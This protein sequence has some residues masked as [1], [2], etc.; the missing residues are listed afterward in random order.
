[1][2]KIRFKKLLILT[3][4]LSFASFSLY[5]IQ[6]Y[7]LRQFFL[8]IHNESAS[9]LEFAKKVNTKIHLM[10]RTYRE[11]IAAKDEN[12]DYRYRFIHKILNGTGLC[13]HRSLLFISVMKEFSIPSR[14]LLIGISDNIVH[15]IIAEA[16]IDGRW[17]VFDPL[18]G[19]NYNETVHELKASN[20]T[21]LNIVNNTRNP[22]PRSYP[23]EEYHFNE[24][25]YFN[26]YKTK[27]TLKLK[28]MI[29][30][31]SEGFVPPYYFYRPFFIL[32]ALFLIISI[33]L[34]FIKTRS[35]DKL[36]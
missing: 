36:S 11:K 24:T 29:G 26:W 22:H 27:L 9:N 8:T 6:N 32:G 2:Y 7:E 30:V 14:K 5:F 19:H 33:T 23:I 16:K 35:V 12:Y 15:H 4:L 34:L 18:F 10:H 31:I 20:L 28:S 13:A 1:M 25:S 3:S 17:I 21:L